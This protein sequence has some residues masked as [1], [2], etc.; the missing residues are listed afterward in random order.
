MCKTVTR[1]SLYTAMEIN[2]NIEGDRC[3]TA[4]RLTLG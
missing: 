4:Q 3:E 2:A 1:C